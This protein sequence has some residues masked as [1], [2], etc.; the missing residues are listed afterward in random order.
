MI[1]MHPRLPDLRL[2]LRRAIALAAAYLLAV[3]TCLAAFGLVP[4]ADVAAI[5]LSAAHAAD[6]TSKPPLPVSHDGCT[7]C[8]LSCSAA[9]PAHPPGES[10]IVPP[11]GRSVDMTPVRGARRIASVRSKAAGARAPPTR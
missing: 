1:A 2:P 8:V 11:T 10:W 6:D 9:P 5:C 7:L 4:N 3:Q